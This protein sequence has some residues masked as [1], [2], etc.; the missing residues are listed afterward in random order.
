MKDFGIKESILFQLDM[1][2]QLYLYHTDNI[3]EEEAHWSFSPKGLQVRKKDG[4][5][6]IDWPETESY[7]IGPSSIAWIMWHIIYWWSIALDKNFGE[8]T[9]EKEDILWPGSVEKAKATIESLHNK[10]ISR[11]NDLSDEDFQL[12][13]YAKWPLEDTSFANIALWLNAELMKNAAEIGYGR[14]LYEAYRKQGFK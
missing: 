3:G 9:L 13:H 5:W 10:W 12:K 1:C 14:F 7:E 11:L 8:G 4:E 2:W 6:C